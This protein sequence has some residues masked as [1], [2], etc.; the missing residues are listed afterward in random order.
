M[1]CSHKLTNW[2]TNILVDDKNIILMGDFK[3][4]INNEDDPE[5]MILADTLQAFRTQTNG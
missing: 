3:I 2:I 4:N 1:H 5:A